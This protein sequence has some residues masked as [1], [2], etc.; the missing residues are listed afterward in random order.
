MKNKV[1][2]TNDSFFKWIKKNKDKLT[3]VV[4]TTNKN[5]ISVNYQNL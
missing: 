5:I 1:F 2:K 3:K 4:I